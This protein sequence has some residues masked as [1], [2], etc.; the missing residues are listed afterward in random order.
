MDLYEYD[1]DEYGPN[2]RQGNKYA[3]SWP[4]QLGVSGSSGSGKTTMLINLL[5]G[6]K[7][8]KEDGERYILCDTAVLIGR[9]LDE[10][11]WNI[12]RKFYEEEDILFI[13][14]PYTEIP[15]VDEFSPEV[16]TLVIFE[17]IMDAP[18]KVQDK[19]TGYFIRGRHRNVSSIYVAQRFFAIPKAIREN[20]SYISLHGGYGNLSDTKRIIQ[21][22]T[23]ESETLAPV[24]NDL[25]LNWEFIVFDRRRSRTDPLSIRLRWDTSLR[26][27]CNRSQFD[28]S[29]NTDQSEFNHSSI[30]VLSAIDSKFTSYGQ[31]AVAEAKRNGQLIA[32]TKNFP[33]PAERKLLLVDASKVKNSDTWTK[34]IFREAYGVNNKTLGIEWKKFKQLVQQDMECGDEPLPADS[35]QVASTGKLFTQYKELVDLSR[36]HPLDNEK[37]VEGI[38]YLLHIFS[39]D[40][41]DRKVLWEG[42]MNLF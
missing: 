33:S 40:K 9:Y 11:K 16:A 24:I 7:K 41:M 23:D 42:I 5:I 13:A 27:Y 30:S 20:L 34:Y 6:T 2:P 38:N 25:S 22:Y 10:P 39:K 28:L 3:P 26:S 32:F 14:I 18:K 31:K 17:D 8:A 15:D 12:V 19:I 1:E 21:L 37:I 29:S 35:E 36:S 4:F